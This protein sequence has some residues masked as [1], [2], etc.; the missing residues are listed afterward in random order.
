MFF[1]GKPHVAQRIFASIATGQFDDLHNQILR[2]DRWCFV[3]EV[4]TIDDFLTRR[5]AISFVEIHRRGNVRVA[6][7]TINIWEKNFRIAPLDRLTSTFDLI[8]NP[9]RFAHLRMRRMFD[10]RH[11]LIINATERV[12]IVDRVH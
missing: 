11:D 2:V 5:F 9:F 10:Q 8:V 3:I 6:D 12:H 7:V 1:R 4:T